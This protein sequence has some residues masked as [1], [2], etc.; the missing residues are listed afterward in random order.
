VSR[1]LGVVRGVSGGL[2][3]EMPVGTSVKRHQQYPTPGW[4]AQAI[5]DRYFPWLGEADCVIEPSCGPGS[6]LAAIP[7]HVPALGVEI[8]PVL[9][10][11]AQ[12]NTG[13]EVLAIRR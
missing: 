9:A 8:D 5:V 6:F 4:A 3:G 13:R 1:L 11:A 7:V 12:I 2:A 10:R